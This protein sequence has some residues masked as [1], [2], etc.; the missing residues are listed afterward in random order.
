MNN[1]CTLFECI[2]NNPENCDLDSV[3]IRKANSGLL[4]DHTMLWKIRS[5]TITITGNEKLIG[6]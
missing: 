2:L 6:S 5:S 3:K 1:D 4:A